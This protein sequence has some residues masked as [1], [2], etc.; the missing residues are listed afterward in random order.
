MRRQNPVAARGA[1]PPPFPHCPLTGAPIRQTVPTERTGGIRTEDNNYSTCSDSHLR[2]MGPLFPVARMYSVT[3]LLVPLTLALSQIKIRPDTSAIAPIGTHKLNRSL[4]PKLRFTSPL[5]IALLCIAPI[6]T[7]LV[8]CCISSFLSFGLLVSHD[9]HRKRKVFRI[10]R[11]EI[12][13]MKVVKWLFCVARELMYFQISLLKIWKYIDLNLNILQTDSISVWWWCY[14]KWCYGKWWSNSLQEEDAGFQ[15]SKFQNLQ[16]EDR[17]VTG[18][19]DQDCCSDCWSSCTIR[20]RFWS[21]YLVSHCV[22]R[23]VFISKLG[24]HILSFFLFFFC[25]LLALLLFIFSPLEASRSHSLATPH[26]VGLLWMSDQPDA[27][28]STWQHTALT[29]YRHPCP[30]RD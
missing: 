11:E 7:D 17:K 15:D 10:T 8:M 4:E 12:L 21:W 26:S 9:H 25:G 20:S 18:P 23:R 2:T 16:T 30:Q 6:Y 24:S 3:E 13:K 14:V 22:D 1:S 28:T 27:E 29:R 19:F 5:V